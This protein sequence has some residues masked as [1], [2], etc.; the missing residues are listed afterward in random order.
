MTIA[1]YPDSN[2][3][4]NAIVT[5]GKLVR[6]VAWDSATSSTGI[7]G[8]ATDPNRYADGVDMKA[9]ATAAAPAA[10]ALLLPGFLHTTVTVINVTV[11]DV[12]APGA[13]T[14][15]LEIV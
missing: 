10:T 7:V 6:T 1:A 5:G 8:D 15:Y 3:P 14:G 2:R 13:G 11:T 12:G 4:A 9:A